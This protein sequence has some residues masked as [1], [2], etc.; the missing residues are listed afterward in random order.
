MQTES[1]PEIPTPEDAWQ[2]VVDTLRDATLELIDLT[3]EEREALA[4]N[5][6]NSH[7]SILEKY[8][9]IQPG[10]SEQVFLLFEQSGDEKRQANQEY[11]EEVILPKIKKRAFLNGM[12]G[13]QVLP[14]LTTEG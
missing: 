2:F 8:E 7:T 5:F 10:I 4:T 9:N 6:W 14:P 3:S 11:F 12:I 13:R 1:M